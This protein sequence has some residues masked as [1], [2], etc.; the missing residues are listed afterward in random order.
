MCNRFIIDSYFEITLFRQD[1]CRKKKLYIEYKKGIVEGSLDMGPTSFS[2][3]NKL[4][5]LMIRTWQAK[6]D[7]S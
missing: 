3:E 6:Y 1:E 4:D 7:F 2:K 5:I